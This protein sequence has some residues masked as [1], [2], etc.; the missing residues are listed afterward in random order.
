MTIALPKDPGPAGWNAILPAGPAS[1][2][3]EME[4]KAD[5]IV[6][7]A[8]FA[9]LAAARRLSQLHTTDRIL[10][11][12]A[13]RL[14]EGPAGRNSGF[15]IDLPHDLSSKHYGG[16]TDADQGTIADNRYAMAFARDMVDAFGLS[17]ETFDPCGK[18]NGAA[19]AK[20]DTHNRDY[21][22]HLSAL[23]EPHRYLDADQMR[24]ITGSDY[25]ISG[26]QTPGTV[27]LQPALY[28]RGVAEGL[29]SNRISIHDKSPVTSLT[30]DGDWIAK[31]PKGSVRAPRVIL[32]VNGHLQSYGFFRGRFVHVHTY[33]SMTEAMN[34]QE[35]EVLGG[36]TRWGITPSDPMGTTV[37]KISGKG[38]DRIV[39]RNH[40][41]YDPKLE[42]SQN[43]E[44]RITKM[45]DEAFA[46]RFPQLSKLK[47]EHRWGGRL[48]LALNNVQVVD[49]LAPGLFA[50]CCQNGLGTVRGTLA[51]MLAADLASGQPSAA[52]DRALN[53][54]RPMRLPP[55]A[56][57]A[58]IARLKFGEWRAG[59]EF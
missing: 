22:L 30:H 4:T 34:S 44:M 25:Y 27:M 48:C 23:G 38:G 21:A 56:S 58:A 26:L 17:Q 49:E 9:G 32:T 42:A 40:F 16:K 53:S 8:G 10:V 12:D 35:I 37:R 43:W 6:I 39:I 36:H 51:G 15:M 19:T 28:V 7:G 47:M 31:T 57:L 3:L 46:A 33:A 29:R 41:S 2:P 55:F 52:L 5:W 54:P 11:L 24:E 20:G 59:D 14:A 45:H 18:I 50:G 13:V 1:Q